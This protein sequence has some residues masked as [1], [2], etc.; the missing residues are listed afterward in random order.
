MRFFRDFAV[1]HWLRWAVGNLRKYHELVMIPNRCKWSKG[2][3]PYFLPGGTMMKKQ[4]RSRTA[5]RLATKRARKS[6]KN[7]PLRRKSLKS[8]KPVLKVKARKPPPPPPKSAEQLERERRAAYA[9]EQ[10]ETAV[11]Y[12]QEQK[13]EKAKALFEKVVSG[14]VLELADRARLHLN[15]CKQRIEGDNVALKGPEDHYNI[16]VALINAGRLDEAEQHL[17]KVLKSQP[18]ADHAL[19]AMAAVCSLR[20]DI[21]DALSNLKTAI[22][23]EPRNRYLARNDADFTALAED[24]RFADLA[25]PEKSDA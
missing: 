16:A 7:R 11:R 8:K 4:A 24:P 25:Y 14:P 23:L 22:D 12:L 9:L 21:E 1:V 18:R 20:G 10:Y 2:R 3:W 5:A 6:L 15:T 19:Y 17:V 13:Y